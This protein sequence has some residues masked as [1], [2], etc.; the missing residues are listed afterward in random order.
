MN[1]HGMFHGGRHTPA[2]LR[3]VNPSV[4]RFV[5][6]YST[7]PATGDV[8]AESRAP[9]EANAPIVWSRTFVLAHDA[10]IVVPGTNVVYGI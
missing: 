10:V 6:R 9:V 2:E 4:A 8:I 5:V 1:P 7:I 3:V